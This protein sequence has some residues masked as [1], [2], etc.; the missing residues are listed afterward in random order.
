MKVSNKTLSLLLIIILAITI[1]GTFSSLNRIAGFE[2]LTGAWGN[3][4]V[5]YGS[6]NLTISQS[7]SINFTNDHVNFG[8]GYVATNATA[9]YL[10][11]STINY[12]CMDFTSGDIVR[13]LLLENQGNANVKLNFSNV[14]YST[15][16]IGGTNPGYAWMWNDPENDASQVTC[17]RTA[18]ENKTNST[19]DEDIWL[20]ISAAGELY[21]VSSMLC[22]PFNATDTND[23]INISFKILVPSN[24]PARSGLSDTW[25]ASAVAV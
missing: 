19:I 3:A 15:S 13:P 1:L 5:T 4:T 10:E 16:L 14:N 2:A 25:T 9:C 20:N 18:V 24:A 11:T 12:G 7:L 22:N 23:V 8:S 21:N 6:V 17:I